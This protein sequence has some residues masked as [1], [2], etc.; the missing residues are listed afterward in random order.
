MPKT[1]MV[2]CL[3]M[4][5]FNLVIMMPISLLVILPNSYYSGVMN[6]LIIDSELKFNDSLLGMA[7]EVPYD[8][9]LDGFTI[10]AHEPYYKNYTEQNLVA[11]FEDNGFKVDTTEVHWV[12]K[13]M[14]VTK[15]L[16]APVA[17]VDA[18]QEPVVAD[19]A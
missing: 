7:G 18:A 17:A 8:R 14:V 2:I 16:A 10:I 9:V 5:L 3:Y 13:C 6:S 15:P 4:A 11:L 12:S 1:F 19:A